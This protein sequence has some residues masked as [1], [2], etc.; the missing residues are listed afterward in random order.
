[1]WGTRSVRRRTRY[2][3]RRKSIARLAKSGVGASNRHLPRDNHTRRLH[4]PPMRWVLML[5]VILAAVVGGEAR[6][7]VVMGRVAV[8]E[9]VVDAAVVERAVENLPGASRAV[10]QET[11]KAAG[12]VDAGPLACW[13]PGGLAVARSDCDAAPDEA[14][15]WDGENRL[16]GMWRGPWKEELAQVPF[17]SLVGEA[18]AGSTVWRWGYD[19]RSRRV[20]RDEPGS[21][22]ERLRT[23]TVFAGGTSAAEYTVT[24]AA[25]SA[26]TVPPAPT[27]QHVRGPDLGGGTK[28]L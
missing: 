2:L 24:A 9:R 7:V 14:L 4:S 16:T 11:R 18:V 12:L 19:H 10:V 27:V 5:F 25:G 21:G 17:E 28:G 15:E 3:F 13:F 8:M 22:G 23:V 26:W 20:Q 1:M 6:A